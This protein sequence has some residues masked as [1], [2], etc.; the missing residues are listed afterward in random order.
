MYKLTPEVQEVIKQPHGDLL[1]GDQP[2]VFDSVM[3][4]L[5]QAHCVIAV[6]D[7]TSLNLVRAGI[8]P[9]LCVVDGKTQRNQ[10]MEGIIV[11]LEDSGYKVVKVLNPPATISDGLWEAMDRYISC[12]EKVAI[13]VDGEEDLATIPAVLLAPDGAVICYGQP[14]EGV[15][16]IRVNDEIKEKTKSLLEKMEVVEE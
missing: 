12:R 13:L 2:D 6:G 8:K 14:D 4:E 16:L 7:L 9:R 11:M 15:V 1:A 5:T 10:K 3:A